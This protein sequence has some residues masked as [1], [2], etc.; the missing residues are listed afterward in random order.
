VPDITVPRPR[1]NPHRSIREGRFTTRFV[2][3]W[4]VIVGSLLLVEC[5]AYGVARSPFSSDHVLPL[6]YV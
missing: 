4:Y 2:I 5:E 6:L 1:S 3:W